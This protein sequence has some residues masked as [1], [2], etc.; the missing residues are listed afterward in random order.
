VEY[1]DKVLSGEVYA[2]SNKEDCYGMLVGKQDVLDVI[3]ETQT[4]PEHKE[5]LN[6]WIN[7]TL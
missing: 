5:A 2:L 4:Q 6:K 7:K 1:I 3:P